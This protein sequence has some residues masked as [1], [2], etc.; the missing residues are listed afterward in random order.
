MARSSATITWLDVPYQE[1]DAAKRCGARWNPRVRAWYLPAG[2]DLEPVIKWAVLEPWVCVVTARV[3]CPSCH[4]ATDAVAIGVPYHW[5]GWIGTGRGSDPE[6]CL[7]ADPEDPA[8]WDAMHLVPR[9]YITPMELREYLELHYDYE[10]RYSSEVGR[11]RLSN[12]CG[13]CGAVIDDSV[14]HGPG[15]AF[16]ADHEDG[17]AKDLK[18][19]RVHTAGSVYGWADEWD[20][21]DRELYDR[22][23]RL[24]ETLYLDVFE[25]LLP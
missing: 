18:F 17:Y 20:P 14:L 8:C 11:V 10:P 1:K 21:H 22:A 2:M 6:T 19:S 4:D 3:E 9:L 12:T 25:D 23:E 16:A 15:G 24:H 13:R 7:E 5:Q